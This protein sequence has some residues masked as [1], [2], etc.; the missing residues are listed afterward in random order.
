MAVTAIPFDPKIEE[1]ALEVMRNVRLQEYTPEKLCQMQKVLE[2]KYYYWWCMDMKKEEYVMELFTEDFTYYCFAPT[3]NN[4]AMQARA[5]KWVNAPMQTMHMG[6]Q[7]MIW[8]MDE[9]HARGLFQYEDHHVYVEGEHEV[10]EGWMVYCD[11]FVRDEKGVWHISAL[12][13]GYRQMDG[14]FRQPVAPPDDWDWI[15]EPKETV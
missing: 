9:T 3:P 13:M 4:R 2:A 14:S 7:P 15:P 11:D 5:A 8:M 1:L 6:H 10:V 12:R